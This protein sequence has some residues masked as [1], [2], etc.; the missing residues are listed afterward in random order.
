M[1]KINLCKNIIDEE[2]YTIIKNDDEPKLYYNINSDSKG[3]TTSLEVFIDTCEWLEQSF[4]KDKITEEFN[5]LNQEEWK[6]EIFNNYIVSNKAEEFLN[7]LTP[8]ELST[9][10][11]YESWGLLSHPV[12]YTLFKINEWF[13]IIFK[14]YN[15]NYEFSKPYMAKVPETTLDNAKSYITLIFDPLINL[16]TN[17][18]TISINSAGIV[19]EDNI[20][21]ESLE[22]LKEIYDYFIEEINL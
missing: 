14:I 19:N 22:W 15:W 7:S 3:N 12:F 8:V 17:I 21:I 10:Y 13:Y 4:T 5:K 2:K 11:S 1:N 20:P 18:G 9:D 16:V 6:E